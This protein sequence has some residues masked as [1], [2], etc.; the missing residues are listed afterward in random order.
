MN[1]NKLAHVLYALDGTK[2]LITIDGQPAPVKAIEWGTLYTE[3]A[4]D[5]MPTNHHIIMG[6]PD[7]VIRR[8]YTRDVAEL[9]VVSQSN[10]EDEDMVE[11]ILK[12][13]H[14]EPQ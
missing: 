13:R 7:R 12:E 8:F 2:A 1:N 14:D 5:S 4:N 11:I 10:G 9:Q 6:T 3:V